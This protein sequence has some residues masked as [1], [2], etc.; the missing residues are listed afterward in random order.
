MSAPVDIPA[1]E[2][3]LVPV[4][5]VLSD[6]A[7]RGRREMFQLTASKAHLSDE[8]LSELLD[9]GQTKANNRIG[10]ALSALARSKAIDRPTR[11]RYVISQ[12][13]RSVLA[14]HPGGLTHRVIF[15]EGRVRR[16]PSS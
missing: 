5:Q 14:A 7:E 9:S 8:Q 10:W 13:G 2:G 16:S 4:L 6:G 11:G 3:F 12:H 1:W 15:P